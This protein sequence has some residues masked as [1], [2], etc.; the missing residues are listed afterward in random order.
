MN[1]HDGASSDL[2][3]GSAIPLRS[4]PSSGGSGAISNIRFRV[5]AETK[6]S[7]DTAVSDSSRSKDRK[8]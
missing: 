5:E 4:L 6:A 2:G 1:A 3:P 8:A 7:D